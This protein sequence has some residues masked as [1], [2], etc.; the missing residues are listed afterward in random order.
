MTG[1]KFSLRNKLF[2]IPF[3]GQTRLTSTRVLNNWKFGLVTKINSHRLVQAQWKFSVPQQFQTTN[4]NNINFS[5]IQGVSF[6]ILKRASKVIVLLAVWLQITTIDI[7]FLWPE[8]RQYY[9]PILRIYLRCV[10][11]WNIDRKLFQ[12]LN[13]MVK[14]LMKM[15]VNCD[16]IS[17]SMSDG[18]VSQ[19]G[20]QVVIKIDG[21]R[22]LRC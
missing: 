22:I 21:R 16:V 4:F 6:S 3:Q 18:V 10:Q 17:W 8:T 12:T 20:C 11:L 15:R 5:V 1:K 9:S 2:K 19:K 13:R 14:R 7:L